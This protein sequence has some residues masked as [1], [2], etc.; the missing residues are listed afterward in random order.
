MAVNLKQM[1]QYLLA[2]EE[3]RLGFTNYWSVVFL[4]GISPTAMF[5]LA[6]LKVLL[7]L[8]FAIGASNL[9]ALL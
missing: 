8:G 6:K 2:G 9:L 1:L 3:S 4:P 7:C 5:W